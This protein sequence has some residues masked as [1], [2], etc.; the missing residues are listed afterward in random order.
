MTTSQPPA[1]IIGR[2]GPDR[3]PTRGGPVAAPR[4]TT[5]TTTCS[6]EIVV[7]T[8]ISLNC[9]RFRTRPAPSFHR[10]AARRP[11]RYRAAPRALVVEHRLVQVS[12]SATRALRRSPTPSPSCRSAGPQRAPDL[13]ADPAPGRRTSKPLSRRRRALGSANEHATDR[14]RHS[15]PRRQ[16]RD[17][18]D[19]PATSDSVSACETRTPTALA[20]ATSWPRTTTSRCTGSTRHVRRLD[21][22]RRSGQDTSSPAALSV[23]CGSGR[24]G[25]SLR[26]PG[27]S[28]RCG[29]R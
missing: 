13:R 2:T 6:F 22:L 5:R 25:W 16:Y 23:G 8:P 21:R 28:T 9:A 18:L 15:P 26:S 10:S 1:R 14:H 27:T 20:R 4:V 3:V 11:P 19:S 12:P 7:D 24:C 17:R 29:R